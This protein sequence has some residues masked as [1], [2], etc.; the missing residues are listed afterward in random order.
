MKPYYSILL[1]A[2]IVCSSI[3]A[4]LHSYSCAENYIIADMNQALEK[5]LEEKEGRWIT[6]DTITDYRSHLQISA[7]RRTSVVNYAVDDKNFGLCSKRIKWK[8]VGFQS[9]ANCSMASVFAMSDQRL[10]A[11]LTLL[12]ML[13]AAI[14]FRYFRRSKDNVCQEGITVL[15]RLKFDESSDMF[16][17]MDN[18]EVSLTPM[19]RQLLTMFFQADNHQLS[20]QIIADALWPKK[21]DAS[22]TLYTLIRRIRPILADNGLKITSGRGKDY[23][24][25]DIS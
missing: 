19:Q 16:L 15:G 17:T 3:I 5:T 14:S 25:T 4:S 20:K 8:G 11:F 2:L 23:Q 12:A 22:D 18:K 24:L 1:F 6:P 10:S 7:L 13:W 21:P 9:Y